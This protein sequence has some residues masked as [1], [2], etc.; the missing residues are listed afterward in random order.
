MARVLMLTPQLPYPPRQGTALRNWGLLRGLAAHHELW[1]LS[2]AAPDQA[3]E[4]PPALSTRLKGVAMLP[5]PTRAPSQ[6]LR[7][8]LTS[9]KPDLIFRLRSAAFEAQLQEW[10]DARPFDWLLVEGLEL[11]LAL[12]R[13]WARPTPP[14]VAFD[15]HNCEYLLQQ[16][17]FQTDLRQPRRWVG[18]AY[19][20]LQWRRLRRHEAAICRRA[21]LVTAVSTADAAA[22]QRLAPGITPLVIPNGLDVAEYSRW[23][24]AAPLQQPAFVFTGTLD[25]RP[26]VDGA[27]WFAAEV[28]PRIRAALPEARAYLVGQRPHPRLEALRDAPGVVITGA[29]PDTRPYLRAATVYV[30]PLRVGGGTRF[31]ILE[32]GAMGRAIVSTTLGAEGFPNVEQAVTLAD[33]AAAFAEACITLARDP[34]LRQRRGTQAQ[35]FVRAYDWEALLPPLIERLEGSA[36][37]H[38]ESGYTEENARWGCTSSKHENDVGT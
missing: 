8:L 13:V 2:F 24:E 11:T 27:L 19:S 17:A 30:V 12:E 29:V 25:F 6:R 16:R 31:K 38:F 26:N 35:A 1:L 3:G 21:E 33:D 36:G 10:L 18:A 15:A 7:D 9:R 34:A 22:L 5:Q 37:Q 14:R 23:E 32:A 28:W 4:M 20:W